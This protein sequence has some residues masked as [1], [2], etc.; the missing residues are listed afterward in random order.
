MQRAGRPIKIDRNV[1]ERVRGSACPGGESTS[2]IEPPIVTPL[3]GRAAPRARW[4]LGA[5]S[6]LRAPGGRPWA[7]TL[8]WGG[9]ALAASVR[10]A[11]IALDPIVATYR[12]SSEIRLLNASYQEARSRNEH[13]KRQI[14]YLN[15][16][17]G[18][19]EEARRLGWV[20]AG[21]LPLLIMPQPATATAAAALPLAQSGSPSRSSHDT[22][23]RAAG[24]GAGYSRESAGGRA[25]SRSEAIPGAPRL[26][27]PPSPPPAI[28]AA[29]GPKPRTPV[30]EQIQKAIADWGVTRWLGEL[31][32]GS[33]AR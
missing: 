4:R 12:A 2:S 31:L 20:R 15:S 6:V 3:K 32:K 27:D 33:A 23:R 11:A 28:P 26:L 16:R 5:R 25:G 8:L 18:V 7:W 19:E 13:L 22:L 14:E 10:L 30:A 21:E 29:T 17:A 9:L 1:W 24:K